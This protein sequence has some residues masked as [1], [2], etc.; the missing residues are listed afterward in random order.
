MTSQPAAHP[1]C[2]EVYASKIKAYA[3]SMTVASSTLM[4]IKIQRKIGIVPERVYI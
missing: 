4:G 2:N 1:K 3:N